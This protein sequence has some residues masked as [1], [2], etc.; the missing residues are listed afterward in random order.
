MASC[1]TKG[2]SSETGPLTED[3][4]SSKG[5]IEQDMLGLLENQGKTD[6][7]ELMEVTR[8]L[9]GYEGWNKKIYLQ[10]SRA[11]VSEIYSPPRVTKAAVSLSHLNIEPGLAL[12]LTT[13]DEEGKA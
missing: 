3:A 4:V 1:R 5:D 9:G 11:S 7:E 6:M 8:D 2:K 12:D 13:T 10:E